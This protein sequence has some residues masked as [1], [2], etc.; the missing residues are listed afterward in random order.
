M[1]IK[2]EVLKELEKV[3]AVIL[4]KLTDKQKYQVSDKFHAAYEVAFRN[5]FYGWDDVVPEFDLVNYPMML[6]EDTAILFN[7]GE[8]VENPDYLR[9]ENDELRILRAIHAEAAHEG[10]VDGSIKK[11][12]LDAPDGSFAR[13]WCKYRQDAIRA[14]R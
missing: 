4:G 3:N 9:I 5:A 1:I 8:R 2:C 6:N 10:A 12:N 14:A 7:D 13:T 11:N